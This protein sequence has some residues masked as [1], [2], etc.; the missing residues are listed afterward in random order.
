MPKKTKADPTGQARNRNRGTRRLSARLTNAERQVKALFRQIPRTS[1]RV[2]RIVNAEQTTV[3]DYEFTPQ[4]QEALDRA[5]EFILNQQLLETQA[6]Q[7]PFDWYWKQDIELPYRQ[8]TVEEVRDFNQLIAGA[9]AAGVL[10][11]GLSPREVPIEQ[12][13]LSEPYRSAL[14]N[15]QISNFTVIKSLSERTSA[16]VLQRINAGI[17]AG[18]TPTTIANEISKR[19]DVSRSNAKRI[20]ETEINRAYNDAKLNAANVLGQETGLRAAVLHISALTPTTRDSHAARHGNAYTAADQFQWWEQGANR[21]NCKCTTRSVLIDR[22]GKVV[23]TE[24]QSELKEE[25][26]FFDND[27]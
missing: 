12:V 4:D 27:E 3:Y 10:I 25:R 22:N 26:K 20:S 7:M 24:L 17:E 11:D 2:T 15:I 16:Q 21:I 18:S 14:N 8:G 13:L 5:V 1:R 9:V 6:G 23:Q 19:F